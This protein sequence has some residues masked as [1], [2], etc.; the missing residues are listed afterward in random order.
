MLGGLIWWRWGRGSLAEV[1]EVLLQ[2]VWFW[3]CGEDDP[4]LSGWVELPVRIA[5]LLGTLVDVF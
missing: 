1:V 4:R 3:R 5:V 2:L